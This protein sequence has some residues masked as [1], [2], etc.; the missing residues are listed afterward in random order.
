MIFEL[1]TNNYLFKPHKGEYFS[2][3]D[4]HLALMIETLGKMPKKFALG[5]KHSREYFNKN[6][7][8]INIKDIKQYPISYLLQEEYDFDMEDAVKIEE[9]L[10]PMLEYD[11]KKRC[12]ALGA[13]KATWLKQ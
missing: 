1:L 2:K 8:M 4:D 5:G 13:L 12:S 9:F 3:D 10:T 11:P 6:G 7:E